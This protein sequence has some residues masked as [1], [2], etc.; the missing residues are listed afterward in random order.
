MRVE[1]RSQASLEL[2]WSVAADKAV[3]ASPLLGAGARGAPIPEA[4]NTLLVAGSTFLHYTEHGQ[5]STVALTAIQNWAHRMCPR[6]QLLCFIRLCA[7]RDYQ[8]VGHITV[9]ML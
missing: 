7:T 2:S 6:G 3:V 1:L 4:P 9:D 8:R 5:A